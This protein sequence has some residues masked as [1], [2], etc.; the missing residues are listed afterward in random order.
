MP[1]A[2]AV[3][4]NR[5]AITLTRAEY[6]D[7]IDARDHAL[8]MRDIASGAVE[9]LSGAE[10][11]AYL[12]G[13]TPLAFWRRHRGMTQAALAAWIGIAQPLGPR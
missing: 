6:E 12:A 11:D 7:L 5:R 2:A 8:A 13:P 1:L 10:L 4:C 9:T 3:A